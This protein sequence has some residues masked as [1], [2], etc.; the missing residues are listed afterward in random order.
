MRSSITEHH[1][2][3]SREVVSLR[4]TPLFSEIQEGCMPDWLSGVHFWRL[5]DNQRRMMS[6][7]SL[8]AI[9]NKLIPAGISF[10]HSYCLGQIER[11][12]TL[13][14]RWVKLQLAWLA[15][16]L[17]CCRP[18]LWSSTSSCLCRQHQLVVSL[19]GE[20]TQFTGIHRRQPLFWSSD[21]A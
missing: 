3:V 14:V 11:S 18:D 6:T 20:L 21:K 1:H 9:L 16:G 8:D 15:D 5:I 7:G 10:Q 12:S 2:Q 13:T 19:R 4:K 17:A